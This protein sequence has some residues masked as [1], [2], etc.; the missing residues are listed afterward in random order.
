MYD[1]T[2]LK[3]MGL[4]ERSSLSPEDVSVIASLDSAH[5]AGVWW[6]LTE[7]SAVCVVSQAQQP[8]NGGCVGDRVS[9]Q[10]T[11]RRW[12]VALA[13]MRT[14]ISCCLLSGMFKQPLTGGGLIHRVT[15]QRTQ[16]RWVTNGSINV[17]RWP[18]Q[19]CMQ[20]TQLPSLM[21]LAVLEGS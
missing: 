15:Q 11:Q 7:D 4:H 1:D 16:R 19:C 21:M 8:L 2:C 12:A 18:G 17:G 9:R 20:A 6:G 14:R 10:R 3:V 13:P 5:S